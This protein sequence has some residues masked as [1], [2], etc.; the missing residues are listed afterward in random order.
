MNNQSFVSDGEWFIVSYSLVKEFGSYI[1][2]TGNVNKK[3]S[4]GWKAVGWA[5]PRPLFWVNNH[6]PLSYNM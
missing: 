5:T 1:N 4:N 6:S 2:F 3:T